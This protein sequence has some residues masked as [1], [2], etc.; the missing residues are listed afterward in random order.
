MSIF[1]Q[2]N[3]IYG[4]SPLGES[5]FD[6]LGRTVEQDV[7]DMRAGASAP[8]YPT[9]TPGIPQIS[10]LGQRTVEEDVLRMYEGGPAPS[11]FPGTPGVPYELSGLGDTKG[12][13]EDWK[14]YHARAKKAAA[15]YVVLRGQGLRIASTLE[16]GKIQKYLIE[17]KDPNDRESPEYRYNSVVVDLSD[18]ANKDRYGSSG[19]MEYA[20]RRRQGRVD[21]LEYINKHLSNW[22]A[23]AAKSYG[24]TPEGQGG[25]IPAP[26]PS[27]PAEQALAKAQTYYALAQDGKQLVQIQ[28]FYGASYQAEQLAIAQNK[29]GVQKEAA[30]LKKIAAQMMAA[31][32][33]KPPTTEI[34]YRDPKSKISPMMWA[35]GALAAGLL[36]MFALKGK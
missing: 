1:A 34:V 13:A 12:D 28:N 31:A 11:I 22:V 9:I 7:L 3:E 35:G 15:D 4:D 25:T 29:P 32:G 18:A 8:A 6:D 17:E 23:R 10:G 24:Y 5:V 27:I 20:E 14:E 36:A 33:Q 26:N 21:K 19:Y 30:A 16:R 2:G